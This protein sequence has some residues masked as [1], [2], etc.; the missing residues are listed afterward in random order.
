M[1]EVGNGPTGR[2]GKSGKLPMP[3]ATESRNSGGGRVVVGAETSPWP[4]PQC[5]AAKPFGFNSGLL[6][7]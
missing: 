6:D 7:C 3:R 1:M 2:P 5:K 4:S